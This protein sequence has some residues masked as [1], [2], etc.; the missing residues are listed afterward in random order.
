MASAA[1]LGCGGFSRLGRLDGLDEK[2]AANLVRHA[3]ELGI[4]L[5]DTA[6]AYQTEAIVGRAIAGLRDKL[7]ISTKAL[8][9]R[10]GQLVGARELRH[11]VAESL[12]KLRTDFIDIFHLHGVPSHLYEHSC[13][14]L[15][16]ELR[17]LRES[18]EIRFVG[19]TEPFAADPGHSTLRR[20]A[21]DGFWDVIMVGFNIL[22][23]SARDRVFPAAANHELGV[24]GMC[25]GR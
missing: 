13:A 14:A 21:A 5:I 19:I 12:R 6:P 18:G 24:L 23:P 7:I 11:S 4:N 22:N 8:P 1:G 15:L 20:A 17:R 10:D 2:Q 25:A 9:V 16:P 3:I